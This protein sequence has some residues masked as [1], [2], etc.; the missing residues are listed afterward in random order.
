MQG[1]ARVIR[2]LQDARITLSQDC[3]AALFDHEVLMSE[4]IEFNQ[5]MAQAC[6]EEI[7]TFCD[8]VTAGDAR[9][10]WCLQQNKDKKNFGDRCRAVCRH[11]FGHV[12]CMLCGL[13]CS[14]LSPVPASCLRREEP[15][16]HLWSSLIEVRSSIAM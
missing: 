16:R 3:K 13:D 11:P 15:G 2:C 8:G 1:S 7:A 12:V 10:V 9:V 14:S 5:P 4:S 6:T